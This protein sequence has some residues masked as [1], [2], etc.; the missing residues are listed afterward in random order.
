MPQYLDPKTVLIYRPHP[1][2]T[3]FDTIFSYLSCSSWLIF[4]TFF[5]HSKQCSFCVS[6][7]H[8][9]F[10]GM[11]GA[12][13]PDY[14]GPWSFLS[15]HLCWNVTFCFYLCFSRQLRWFWGKRILNKYFLMWQ[16][17]FE[18]VPEISLPPCIIHRVH[19]VATAASW[20]TV[21]SIMRVKLAKAGEG[22]GCT[23]TPFHYIYHHQ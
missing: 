16:W 12:K 1:V 17:S 15:I 2:S 19:R 21:H 11:S 5:Q 14:H 22:E 18:S 8:N 6:I 13:S 23:P 9:L 20:R 10:N 4:Q 7:A 3:S